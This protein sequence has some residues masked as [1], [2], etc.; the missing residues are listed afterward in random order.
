MVQ[1]DAVVSKLF[2]RTEVIGRGRFGVVYKGINRQTNRVVAIKVLNLDT[3]EDEVKEVQQEI[4]FL[5]QLKQAPNITHYQGS[6]LNGTRLWII[7]DYCAGGALR[8]LLKTGP[9][10]E[11]YCAVIMRELLVALH[12]VHKAGVIHRDLKAAN[13]LITKE[14]NIQLCDFGVAAQLTSTSVK[15]TTMAGTPY[16]MAPEVI[17]EGASYNAKVD[18]WS[19]GIT[20]Y[21]I[22]TG[23]PPYSDKDAMRAMQLITKSK[24]PRLEGRQHSGVLKEFVALCLDENPEERPTVEELLSCKLVKSSK[25]VP[26]SIL[27]ELI[28]RYLLWRETKGSRESIYNI[29]DELEKN[30]EGEEEG[31]EIK[32]D[33]DSLSSADYS[34]YYMNNEDSD[35]EYLPG[36]EATYQPT[37]GQTTVNKTVTGTLRDTVK[38]ETPKSLLQLFDEGSE[39]KPPPEEITPRPT[40]Q[41]PIVEIE[42]PN[43]DDLS[44]STPSGSNGPTKLRSSTLSRAQSSIEVPL[45]TR[46]SNT[47]SNARIPLAHT[48]SNLSSASIQAT[49]KTP[50]P[51]KAFPD[52]SS[53]PKKSINTPPQMKPMPSTTNMP[54]L[55]PIN[56]AASGPIPLAQQPP[57]GELKDNKIVGNKSYLTLQMPQPT[58]PSPLQEQLQ[59]PTFPAANGVSPNSETSDQ[60]NQFGVNA[61]QA[62]QV[63]LAMTPLTERS[64]SSVMG[65]ATTPEKPNSSQPTTNTKHTDSSSGSFDEHDSKAAPSSTY[66]INRPPISLPQLDSKLFSDM[67]SK[68]ALVNEIGTLLDQMNNTLSTIEDDFAMMME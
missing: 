50:S 33:F 48:A 62:A 36:E 39:S 11:R 6:Y 66:I 37:Y 63:P 10:E 45:S 49:R 30:K 57:T 60:I 18:V 17:M 43:M 34:N 44:V 65:S 20:A 28:A 55:Q 27:K 8:S 13:I 31:L 58:L 32:W 23:N 53:P 67:T 64:F 9:I 14:G 68:Q 7:M 54:M 52:I 51:K 59:V 15:R 5:S 12:Y 21:E 2:K 4:Q 26:N 38:K 40:K 16:W 56:K 1:E 46:R 42:I 29:D 61:T 24:P 41:S 47:I 25:N 19:L 22:S 3:G 35:H